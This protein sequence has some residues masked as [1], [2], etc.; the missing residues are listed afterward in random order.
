MARRRQTFERDDA[1]GTAL[2]TGRRAQQKQ[3]RAARLT[4]N[5]HSALSSAPRGKGH[6]Q[7]VE[8]LEAVDGRVRLRQDRER[9]LGH[10][11]LLF[12][13]IHGELGAVRRQYVRAG[14]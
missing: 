10:R 7:V 12:G 1:Y 3:V 9:E 8:R 5:N 11:Q 13:I 4:I 2:L 14:H 6:A